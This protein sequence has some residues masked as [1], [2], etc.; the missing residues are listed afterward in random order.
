MAKQTKVLYQG[1]QVNAVELSFKTVA[2]DWNEYE[3]EDGSV[4]RLKAVVSK[5]QRTELKNEA[6][7]EPIFL[8]GSSNVVDVVAAEGEEEVH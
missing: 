8:I 5:I 1:K 7:G 6:T 4:I 3:C 2:E